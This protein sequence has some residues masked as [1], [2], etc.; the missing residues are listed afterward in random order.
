MSTLDGVTSMHSASRF[1]VFHELDDRIG[2][3]A[4]EMLD[5]G[6]PLDATHWIA[7]GGMTSRRQF[8]EQIICQREA[9]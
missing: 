8:P 9:A 3:V 6:G 4:W 7:A 5:L 1:Y 2:K